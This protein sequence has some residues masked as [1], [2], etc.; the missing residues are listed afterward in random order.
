MSDDLARLFAEQPDPPDDET[1]V[2]QVTIRITRRRQLAIALPAILAALLVLAIWAIW[3]AAY[4]FG[5]DA[6][7]GIA[8]IA[9]GIGGFFT[10]PVGILTAAA[11]LFAA[12]IWAWIREQ[13]HG[14]QF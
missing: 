6:L 12:V 9:N 11:L 14:T 3:P 5:T 7:S 13:M 1:F 8:F 10:T 4:L 2:T